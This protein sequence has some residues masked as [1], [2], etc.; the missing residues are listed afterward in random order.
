MLRLTMLTD[1]IDCVVDFLLARHLCRVARV[2]RSMVF[3]SGAWP[4][5]LSCGELRGLTR[6]AGEG[7]AERGAAVQ[8][9]AARSGSGDKACLVKDRQVGAGPAEAQ[10]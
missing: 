8:D 3:C 9:G 4:V 5:V 2:A 7:V 6:D 1:G 10:G